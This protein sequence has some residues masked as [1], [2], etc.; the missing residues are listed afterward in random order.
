MGALLTRSATMACPHGG[1]I[2][3]TVSDAS[4]ASARDAVLTVSD[5]FLVSGCAFAPGGVPHPC[6]SV[7][8]VM[9]AMRVTAARSPVLTIDSQGLCTA[10]DQAPQGP[11]ML[12]SAQ[13]QATAT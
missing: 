13:T 8:W 3:A 6:V 2:M 5:T 9:P 4:R 11:P 12:S 10:A 7:L 1:T